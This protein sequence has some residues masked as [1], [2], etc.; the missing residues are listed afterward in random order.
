MQ[1]HFSAEGEYCVCRKEN[2]SGLSVLHA[3][4]FQQ[5]SF[6]C[7]RDEDPDKENEELLNMYNNKSVW[8]QRID[9]KLSFL[10]FELSRII[11]YN[12]RSTRHKA[13]GGLGCYITQ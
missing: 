8:H 5:T 9:M 1:T 3:P 10:D 6:D 4:C 7:L 12:T 2:L 11:T 13:M